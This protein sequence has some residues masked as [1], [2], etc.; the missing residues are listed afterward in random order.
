MNDITNV[1]KKIISWYKENKRD[2]PWRKTK[3]PYV[4]WV[5]EIILQQTRVNQGLGYY[6]RF[7][8]KFPNLATLAAA[9]IDDILKIWQGLGYYS[10]ARYMH[11]T[12]RHIM[13]HLKGEFPSDPNDLY[14]LKGIGRYSAAAIASI[15]FNKSVPVVDGNV[16]RVL[17]RFFGIEIP[18]N[19]SKAYPKFYEI[20]ETLIKGHNPGIFNQAV[21]EFGAAIC[22]FKAPLCL[23][24]PVADDC[25]AYTNQKTSCFPVKNK[26][27]KV[28]LRYFNYFVIEIESRFLFIKRM[29][30]DIWKHLYEFPVIETKGKIN[31]KEVFN[32][33]EKKYHIKYAKQNKTKSSDFYFHKLTHQHIHAKFFRLKGEKIIAKK[34]RFK[35]L[36][37]SQF[38]SIAVPRL[39][40]K[41]LTDE[42]GIIK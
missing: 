40:E 30:N 12:A 5:S 42:F 2:L 41:Y 38:T 31:T 33:F 13:L 23:N 8:E 19:T 25:Y 37:I 29:G 16:Y 21:M 9:E 4:I 3:N 17:S 36:R 22:R 7:L 15:A 28:R 18:I 1:I 6:L 32:E 20:A 10:R 24:C 11:E 14:K 35:L 39:I 34:R 27:N 26:K